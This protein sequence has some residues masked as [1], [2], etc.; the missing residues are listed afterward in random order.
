MFLTVYDH[1]PILRALNATISQ[2]VL[3]SIVLLCTAPSN[4]ISRSHWW[5][6]YQSEPEQ[7]VYTVMLI[8]QYWTM[9]LTCVSWDSKT[10]NERSLLMNKFL[11]LIKIIWWNHGHLAHYVCSLACTLNTHCNISTFIIISSRACASH[12]RSIPLSWNYH[13]GCG[14]LIY[15]KNCMHFRGHSHNS[16]CTTFRCQRHA[17]TPGVKTTGCFTTNIY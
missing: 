2:F 6:N 17:W 4:P 14:I 1:Y 5:Q 13:L 10:C 9:C 8:N 7:T 3:V 12:Q 15:S 11:I 16:S